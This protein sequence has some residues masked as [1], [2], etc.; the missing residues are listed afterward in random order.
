[1]MR[2]YHPNTFTG[3]KGEAERRPK[4]LNEWPQL[5]SRKED[6]NGGLW[7]WFQKRRRSCGGDQRS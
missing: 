4:Q 1:M 3:P 5:R 6:A 2:R 7:G